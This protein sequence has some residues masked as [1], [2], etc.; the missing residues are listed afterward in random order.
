MDSPVAGSRRGR[1][2]SSFPRPTPVPLLP[3][4]HPGA[5]QGAS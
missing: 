5:P 4:A 1:D 3:Q 2:D